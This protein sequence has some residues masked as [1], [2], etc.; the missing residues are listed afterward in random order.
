MQR[1]DDELLSLVEQLYAAAM[2]ELDW[3]P[4]AL[5]LAHAFDS[6]SCSLQIQN[7][8]AKSVIRLAQTP[9]YTPGLIREYVQHFFEVDEWVKRGLLKP[10]VIVGSEDLISDDELVRTE[11]HNDYQ[12]RL[13]IFYILGT[14]LPLERGEIG[15]IG[16]HHS[17]KAGLFSAEQKTA[18][19]VFAPHFKRALKMRSMLSALDLEKQ[20]AMDSLDRLSLGVLLVGSRC[21][22]LFAN[23]VAERLIA[24][25]AGILST[26][27]RLHLA[28]G[29][30]SS[31]L[32]QLI[33]D[34]SSLLTPSRKGG[35]KMEKLAGGL[36][37]QIKSCD[38]A[39][40]VLV[41]E[42]RSL[43]LLVCPVPPHCR[44]LHAA[45]P[46]AAMIFISESGAKVVSPEI[47]SQLYGLSPA[48]T[49]LVVALL[50]G[51]RLQDYAERISITLNTAKTQLK[52]V[53]EK[54]G[55]A[56]QSDLVR[57][58]LANPILALSRRAQR[59]APPL[60]QERKK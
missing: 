50:E 7:R 5:G 14:A 27:G 56:R 4:L 23:A 20:I 2:G 38:G 49:R 42:H 45:R 30:R 25:S 28:D 21:E 55:V 8:P 35:D 43:S 60:A 39:L 18:L 19:G 57:H 37:A 51:E 33:L 10:G 16:I 3:A 26:C 32:E 48:E 46:A 47:F 6:E 59:A 1:N 17:H 12:R 15:C 36:G 44:T 13:G 34:A 58:I 54:T 53:F 9:N 31:I 52:H 22:I 29:A 41:D 40:S 11:I 24:K